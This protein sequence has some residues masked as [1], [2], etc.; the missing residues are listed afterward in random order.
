MTPQKT[1]ASVRRTPGVQKAL[2]YIRN[3]PPSE[4][5]PSLRGL[6]Q[7]A[8][9]SYVTMWKAARL[10]AAGAGQQG[11]RASARRA[12]G[13]GTPAAAGETIR[14]WQ[15]LT[16]SIQG[17]LLQGRLP[18][19]GALPTIKELCERYRAGYQVVRLALDELCRKR[20]LRRD[21]RRYYAVVAGPGAAPTL[22]IAVLAYLWYAEP[23]QD[24]LKLISDYDQDF[25]REL[26][27]ECHRR[28]VGMELVRYRYVGDSTVAM[29]T[30]DGVERSLETR[31]DT[32]GY[33]VLAAHPTC[34]EPR[35][36]ARLHATGR[37]LVV[38]DEIGGWEM[39]PYLARGG[40]LLRVDARPFAAAAREV[41]HGLSAHG[42]R[43]VA[44]FST[45]HA[46][47]WSQQ[48]LAGLTEGFTAAGTDHLVSTFLEPG[49]QLTGNWWVR[50]NERSAAAK[51]R[52]FY[53]QWKH[54]LPRAYTS[55][56]DPHFSYELDEQLSYAEVRRALEPLFSRALCDTS[57]TCW[58]AACGD[59]VWFAHDFLAAH[60]ARLPLI[61]FGNS[62]QILKKRITTYDFDAAGAACASVEYLVHRGQLPGQEGSGLH[63]QG[64]LVYR[65]G[66]SRLTVHRRR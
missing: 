6:A 26:E 9:V 65:Q 46:D 41:A 19:R 37:P 43:H 8:D 59:T 44:F 60:K 16:K 61:G 33:I 66:L 25:F 13:I 55:Q 17:D 1:G 29:S 63:I 62:E 48:C 10:S 36:L 38:V 12:E 49:S 27:M 35:L 58:V 54:R 45:F 5:R 31:R 32:A 64:A 57:I 53:Q 20:L 56:L 51:L 50:A 21:A 52:S 24:L 47:H 7:A 34:V 4:Q 28:G 39:P 3:L 23:Y 40:R 18:H 2:S 11:L 15:R 14:P 42:H 30:Q 22:K